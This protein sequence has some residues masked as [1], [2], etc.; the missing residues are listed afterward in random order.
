MNTI[1]LFIFPTIKDTFDG[2]ISICP[3]Y[4]SDCES[5]FLNTSITKQTLLTSLTNECHSL[6]TIILI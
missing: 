4:G 2:S 3:H 6:V 5:P 1:A